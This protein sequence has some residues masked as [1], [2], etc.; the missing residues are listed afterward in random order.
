MDF[1]FDPQRLMALAHTAAPAYAGA[2]PFPHAVFDDFL[3]PEA[4]AILAHAFPTPPQ[5]TGWDRYAAAG[6][7]MKLASA[8]ETRLPAAIVRA[9]HEFNS[10]PFVRFLEAL[11]GIPGLLPDPHLLGGGAHLVGRGGHLGVHADFN[12]HPG[13]QAHRR[14]NVLLYLNRDW[15]ADWGGELELWST[16]AGRRVR[17]IA[18]IFNRA[19][20]FNTRSDTF[21]GHPAPLACPEGEYRRSL[22]LYYYSADRP[23]EEKRAP[24]STRYKGLHLP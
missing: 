8:D 12:W 22:A 11:T 10:G 20:I 2:E 1:I 13:L 24:H 14:I 23:E 21:H 9:L 7:E 17:S 16:D 15:P 6:F 19:V 4:A 5:Y 3:R 18:P